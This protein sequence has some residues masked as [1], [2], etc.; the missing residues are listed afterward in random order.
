MDEKSAFGLAALA[1]AVA[2]QRT[3]QTFDQVGIRFLIVFV[4]FVSL[5]LRCTVQS[6]P[7]FLILN[8][9]FT[10]SY[11]GLSHSMLS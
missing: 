9:Q 4:S 5:G 6:D 1:Y 2:D 3:A 11:N 8:F 10:L 7:F